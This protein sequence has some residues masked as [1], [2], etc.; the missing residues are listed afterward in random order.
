LVS[1][2]LG[3][4]GDSDAQDAARKAVRAYD[5]RSV[6]VHEGS[7]ATDKLSGAIDDLRDIGHGSKTAEIG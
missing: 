7:I 6:L 3:K 5:T 4:L 2:V 1:S